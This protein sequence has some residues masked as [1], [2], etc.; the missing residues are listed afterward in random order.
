[1]QSLDV[2]ANRTRVI[3]HKSML[4]MREHSPPTGRAEK[5]GLPAVEGQ[6]LLA[7]L[8]LAENGGQLLLVRSVVKV[9]D[10]LVGFV[11]QMSR[12][13]LRVVVLD[14]DPNLVLCPGE[15]GRREGE[16]KETDACKMAAEAQCR[17]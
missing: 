6:L 14:H 3:S 16:Q 4:Y 15:Q 12:G 9:G 17:K 5:A 8:R 2:N 10:V 1:M 11:G 7:V 13:Q